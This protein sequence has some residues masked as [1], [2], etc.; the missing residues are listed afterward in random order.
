MPIT[1]WVKVGEELPES[2]V[3]VLVYTRDL[4]RRDKGEILLAEY[5]EKFTLPADSDYSDIDW[6]EYDEDS[7]GRYC[8]I[9]WYETHA[10]EGC[11]F[12]VAGE[13]THW[14]PLPN[15]PEDN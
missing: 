6:A 1:E 12:Q 11:H 9:G 15:K 7:G 2:N 4:S 13:V 3:P 14:T 10:Y 8:P 5:A